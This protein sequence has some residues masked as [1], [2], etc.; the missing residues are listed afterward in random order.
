MVATPT[1]SDFSCTRKFIIFSPLM[2]WAE[3]LGCINRPTLFSP[4]DKKRCIRFRHYGDTRSSRKIVDPIVYCLRRRNR[5][6]LT[7]S[8]YFC[9]QLRCYRHFK[10]VLYF[11]AQF[12][13]PG[14]DLVFLASGQGYRFG[15]G[16]SADTLK[17]KA[18]LNDCCS[19]AEIAYQRDV[20]CPFL[21]NK[22]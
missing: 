13:H 18:E 9:L 16:R 10:A 15:D 12:T 22:R 8:Q 11:Y 4:G 14:F 6:Q 7:L 19:H 1:E 20:R 17:V 3:W 2:S 5:P 21:Q